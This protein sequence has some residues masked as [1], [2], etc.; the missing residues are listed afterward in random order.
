VNGEEICYR[1]L[2]QSQ[3]SF[4]SS[5]WHA[6]EHVQSGASKNLVPEKYD[7]LESYWRQSTGTDNWRQ[8][9]GECVITIS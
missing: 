8:K 7:T 6:I 3:F 1:M 4:R 2:D 9:I 5:Y